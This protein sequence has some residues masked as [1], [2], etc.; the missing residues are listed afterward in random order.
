[1]IVNVP[2]L[3][4]VL[5]VVAT[6]VGFDA[7]V[8]TGV[9][10]D[11]V[12][13]RDDDAVGDWI[14]AA[15]VGDCVLAADVGECVLAADVGKYV[16]GAEVVGN[17]ENDVVS[18]VVANWLQVDGNKEEGQVDGGVDELSL[19]VRNIFLVVVGRSLGQKMHRK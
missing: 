15:D 5:G 12:D 3:L 2:L 14:L 6:G 13:C 4:G 19:L 1:M 16:L 9:E 10:G 8:N 11:E 18:T 17:G 7:V